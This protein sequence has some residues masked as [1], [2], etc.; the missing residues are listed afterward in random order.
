MQAASQFGRQEKVIENT[1]N[2]S[3]SVTRPCY[4]NVINSRFKLIFLTA[5]YL[6]YCN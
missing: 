3:K 2:V 5:Y 1:E 4:C 6:I